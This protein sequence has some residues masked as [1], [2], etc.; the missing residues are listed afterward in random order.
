MTKS[1]GANLKGGSF[2]KQ[3]TNAFYR[4]L[5]LGEGRHMKIGDNKTHSIELGKKRTMYL[6][7][8]KKFLEEKGVNKGK[9]NQYMSEENIKDFLEQR[10][11]NLSAKSALD[12]CTGFNSLLKALEQTKVYIPSTPTNKD[13][14]KSFRE[15]LRAEMKEMQVET[16]R[17]IQNLDE[18]LNELK[19]INYESYVV[20]KLQSVTGLRVAESLEVV[21]DFDEYYNPNTNSLNEVIGKGNHEYAPKIIDYQLVQEIQKMESI[22]T[23]SAY[24]EDLKEIGI[25]RSHDIR[26]TYA[27]NIFENK[28]EQG[29]NYKQ[30][31]KEVSKEINHHRKEMTEYYLNRA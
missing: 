31:L 24:R 23:Y 22:P 30:A 27:K 10:T 14:L 2:D 7:D 1:K 29:T 6:N 12:Y 21:K 25:A 4:T 9:I 26:L 5:A 20:A 18:K 28:L 3:I 13:F 15:E 17:Y 19:K 11:D 16:G 8:F